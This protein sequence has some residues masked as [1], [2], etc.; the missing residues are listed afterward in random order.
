M[1]PHQELAVKWTVRAPSPCHLE[2]L[3]RRDRSIVLGQC[4]LDDF[5]SD[6]PIGSVLFLLLHL[7]VRAHRRSRHWRNHV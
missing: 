1:V 6:R 7:L 2:P 3:L 5:P 4:L